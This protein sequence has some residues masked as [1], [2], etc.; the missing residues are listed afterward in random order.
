M[1]ANEIQAWIETN[2][3]GL[4]CIATYEE[5][6]FFYNPTGQL[7]RGVYFTTIKESDGPNDKAGQ[8]DRPGVYRLSIGVGKSAYRKLFGEPPARPAKG[9]RVDLPLDFTAQNVCLPHPIYAWMSWVA[10]NSPAEDQ[11]PVIR[12]LLNLAYQRA[13]HNFARKTQIK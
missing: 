6:S 11:L 1:T 3:S 8:L 5:S 9:E 13:V 7:K 4:R 12:E 10:I 2:Y